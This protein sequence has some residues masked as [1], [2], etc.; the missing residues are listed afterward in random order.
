MP[1]FTT[2]IPVTCPVEGLIVVI[3]DA[4]V[5]PPPVI[6]TLGAISYPIPTLPTI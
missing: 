3:A 5:P 1:G 2:C 6:S 4:P